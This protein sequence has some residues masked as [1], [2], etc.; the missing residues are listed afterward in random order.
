MKLS[1]SNIAW[2]ND[3]LK[4]H[5]LLLNSLGCEGVDIAPSC[6]WKE[7]IDA[8]DRDIRAFKK[9]ISKYNLIIP[10]FHAFLFTKP[11][12][13]LFGD[14]VVRN[15]TILYLKKLIELAGKL[16]VKVM[17]YGSPRSR[18]RGDKPYEKCYFI[19]VDTF[20]KLARDASL[21]DICICIEPLGPS[22]SDFIQSADEGYQL[23][24][25]VGNPHFGLHL[26]S[27]AMFDAREDFSKTFQKYAFV[28]KHFHVRDKGCSPPGYTGIDHSVIGKS[29]SQSSYDG[30]ISIEMKR[31]FGNS[32]EAIKNSVAYVRKNY[33]S[34]LKK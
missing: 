4:E 25:D 9:L 14:K 26:D 31:G 1:V 19:L 29:L 30:F 2:D 15:D 12:L 34:R 8:S 7:P 27:Y 16:S 6:I 11:D 23:V 21:Y 10:A 5:L 17:V 33:F 3:R 18:R 28:L 13:Y 32:K 24:K 22:E 20:R